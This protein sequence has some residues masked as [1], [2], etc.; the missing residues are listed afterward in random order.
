MF[1]FSQKLAELRYR[2]EYD[3]LY[4]DLVEEKKNREKASYKSEA[5]RNEALDP[6]KVRAPEVVAG[7][8]TTSVFRKSVN[9]AV[10][11]GALAPSMSATNTSVPDKLAP[12]GMSASHRVSASGATPRP[13]FSSSAVAQSGSQVT[14]RSLGQSLGTPR[15]AR[16]ST[17]AQAAYRSSH[18]STI[19][20]LDSQTAKSGV[21]F[22]LETTSANRSNAPPSKSTHY[23]SRLAPS[24]HEHRTVAF[25]DGLYEDEPVRYATLQPPAWWLAMPEDARAAAIAAGRVDRPLPTLTSEMRPKVPPEEGLLYNAIKRLK[26]KEIEH[27]FPPVMLYGQV[28]PSTCV[29]RHVFLRAW[30]AVAEELNLTFLSISRLLF[31][32]LRSAV[33]AR[34]FLKSRRIKLRQM[35]LEHIYEAQAVQMGIQAQDAV[36]IAAVP[37]GDGDQQVDLATIT[38]SGVYSGGDLGL[39]SREFQADAIQSVHQ[40]SASPADHAL[41]SEPS[42]NPNFFPQST[43]SANSGFDGIEEGGEEEEEKEKLESTHLSAASSVRGSASAVPEPESQP[44]GSRP[45]QTY[46]PAGEVKSQPRP[47]GSVVNVHAP[48]QGDFDEFDETEPEAIADTAAATAAATQSPRRS[49][50]TGA[51]ATQDNLPVEQADSTTRGSTSVPPRG[52]TTSNRDQDASSR[53]STS[54]RPSVTIPQLNLQ[55][56]AP[57]SSFEPARGSISNRD[58]VSNPGLVLEADAQS[59]TNRT[60]SVSRR[61]VSQAEAPQTQALARTSTTQDEASGFDEPEGEDSTGEAPN[62]QSVAPVTADAAAPELTE[63]DNPE[64]DDAEAIRDDQFQPPGS[65]RTSLTA[66]AAVAASEIAGEEA[67]E[68]VSPRASVDN[69]AAAAA[70]AAGAIVSE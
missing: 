38:G 6:D 20:G 49:S 57:G 34:A 7:A 46:Q 14:S 47:S 31:S 65:T 27:K 41:S 50:Q 61:S 63:F 67:G 42:D 19:L 26:A 2:L 13:T 16:L 58:S 64:N 4:M 28:E 69:P 52:S 5:E 54:S 55:G 25:E 43:E 23:F 36:D 44:V 32:Q 33:V 45:S 62:Q 18:A 51:P 59:L 3:P 60:A 40:V 39:W 21:G 11:R 9:A 30:T 8:G 29:P 1:Q 15:P 53:Q 48:E 68:A 10:L 70:A 22:L 37:G 12:L 66:A 24:L 56:L 17:S 35:F